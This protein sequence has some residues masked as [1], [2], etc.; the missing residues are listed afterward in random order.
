MK[1]N[2]YF[3]KGKD[4]VRVI[5]CVFVNLKRLGFS[6]WINIS[7]IVSGCIDGKWINMGK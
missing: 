7:V 4:K 3:L 2:E 6:L 5:L 1:K